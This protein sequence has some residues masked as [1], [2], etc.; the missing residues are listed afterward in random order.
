M[1][2]LLGLLRTLLPT[3]VATI[4]G[5]LIQRVAGGILGGAAPAAAPVQPEEDEEE[6]FEE[7]DEEEEEEEEEEA[8][9]MPLAVSPGLRFRPVATIPIIPTGE[10]LDLPRRGPGGFI[11]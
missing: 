9:A 10:F 3:A 6:E 11:E 7:E 5:A 8:E 4:G 1:P 2:F